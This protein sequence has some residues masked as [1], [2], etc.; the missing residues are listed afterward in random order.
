LQ[1]DNSSLLDEIR[2]GSSKVGDQE[3]GVVVELKKYIENL[4]AET[5]RLKEILNSKDQLLSDKANLNREIVNLNKQI[6]QLSH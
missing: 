6:S 5:L 1:Q 2:R 3:T 4:K